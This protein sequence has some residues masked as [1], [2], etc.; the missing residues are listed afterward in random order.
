MKIREKFCWTKLIADWNRG[1]WRRVTEMLAEDSARQLLRAALYDV[2]K[3][4]LVGDC[5]TCMMRDECQTA[6]ATAVCCTTGSNLAARTTH[7]RSYA[8]RNAKPAMK[9]AFIPGDEERA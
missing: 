4:G 7:S 8:E 9:K 1:D 3:P 2:R 5:T 6:G